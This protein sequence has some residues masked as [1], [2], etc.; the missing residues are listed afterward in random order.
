MYTSF[1]EEVAQIYRALEERI[2]ESDLTMRAGL[3]ADVIVVIATA[4][5][6]GLH[7]RSAVDPDTVPDGLTGTAFK[8]LL[9]GLVADQ[10]PGSEIGSILDDLGL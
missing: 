2:A 8:L 6:E 9:E 5:V 4:L 10:K 7:I 3:E 1:D